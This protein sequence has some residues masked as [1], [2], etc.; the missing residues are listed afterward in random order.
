MY[1][2]HKQWLT[3]DICDLIWGV[4]VFPKP[5]IVQDTYQHYIFD[6]NVILMCKSVFRKSKFYCCP[7]K[8]SDLFLEL[9]SLMSFIRAAGRSG[10]ACVDITGSPPAFLMCP[11]ASKSFPAR[12]S[13]KLLSINRVGTRWSRFLKPQLNDL[14]GP[15]IT[16]CGLSFGSVNP[17]FL[18]QYFA[19]L[20]IF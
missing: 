9:C 6:L 12:S 8:L 20:S 13:R 5:T 14:S 7:S 10:F 11:I 19:Y 2:N 16:F 15:S 1:A 18:H 17:H 4:Y 3:Q